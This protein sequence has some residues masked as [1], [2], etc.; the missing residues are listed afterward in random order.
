MIKKATDAGLRQALTER[1][2]DQAH[3]EQARRSCACGRRQLSAMDGVV[4]EADEL[5]GEITDKQVLDAAV[6]AAATMKPSLVGASHLRPERLGRRG[7]RRGA[8]GDEAR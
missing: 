2:D 3:V 5:V 7:L 8:G 4:E 1:L 6:V